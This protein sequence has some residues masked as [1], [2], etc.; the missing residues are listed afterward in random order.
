MTTRLQVVMLGLGL[1]AVACGIDPYEQDSGQ[2]ISSE[3]LSRPVRDHV[4]DTSSIAASSPWDVA[5]FWDTCRPFKRW[6][7][8]DGRGIDHAQSDSCQRRNGSW[9]GFNSYDAYCVTNLSN[10][11]GVLH[12]E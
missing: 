3:T 2:E 10:L 6:H 11:D 7:S 9:G 5:S 8:P 12:C 1:G 4:A